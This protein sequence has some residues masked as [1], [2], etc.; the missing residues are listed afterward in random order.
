MWLAHAAGSLLSPQSENRTR[1]R[2]SKVERQTTGGGA[3]AHADGRTPADLSHKLQALLRSLTDAGAISANDGAPLPSQ[4]GA[5][6]RAYGGV[7]DAPQP[8]WESQPLA[9]AREVFSTIQSSGAYDALTQ[10]L[11]T[12]LRA[13]GSEAT[14]ISA[15]LT[16][17]LPSNPADIASMSK[18]AFKD[19]L[20][21]MSYPESAASILPS[22]AGSLLP[23]LRSLLVLPRAE[24]VPLFEELA[25]P[26]SLLATRLGKLPVAAMQSAGQAPLAASGAR[27]PLEKLAVEFLVRSAGAKPREV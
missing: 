10:Q 4:I 22:A 17:K 13:V 8:M 23:K 16:N 6:S 18:E 2:G 9:A 21:G 24:V 7:V 12:Q 15:T 3:Q 27:A 19:L 5:L 1:K 11:A 25:K 20:E 26:L 14:R